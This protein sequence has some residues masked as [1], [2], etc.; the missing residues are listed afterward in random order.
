MWFELL[1]ARVVVA[2]AL[3]AA[4]VRRGVEF[5][6]IRYLLGGWYVVGRTVCC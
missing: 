3:D 4:R 2:I 6:F 5:G 1:A